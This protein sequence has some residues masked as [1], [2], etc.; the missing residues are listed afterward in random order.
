MSGLAGAN[1]VAVIQE[2]M[3]EHD[4]DGDNML[5]TQELRLL[6]PSFLESIGMPHASVTELLCM[7][8][9]NKDRQLDQG[10]QQG[11]IGAIVPRLA[12]QIQKVRKTQDFRHSQTLHANLRALKS[13]M[14][15]NFN[16]YLEDKKAGERSGLYNY[17]QFA[18]NKLN[19]EFVHRLQ[20]CDQHFAERREALD[21]QFAMRRDCLSS[22]LEGTRKPGTALVPK[23]N[24]LTL[25][26]RATLHHL[27]E[28][29][30]FGEAIEL[31]AKI[32][33]ME[34]K[35]LERPVRVPRVPVLP[36]LTHAETLNSEPERTRGSDGHYQLT[37]PRLQHN[38]TGIRRPV[39]AAH[40]YL[41]DP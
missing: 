27:S 35:Q 4:E 12:N 10:E 37:L 28:Q 29:N 7:F 8:D 21:R 30:R 9:K 31:Q 36:N 24:P 25:E 5:D 33:E 22:S 23:P 40:S 41:V 6:D 3:E 15:Q 38:P 11:V 19:K 18:I 20:E 16:Q 2:Q 26:L 1:T 39:H 32:D 17:T 34:T 13:T 14:R